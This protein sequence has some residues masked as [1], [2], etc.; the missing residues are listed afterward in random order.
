MEER[1]ITAGEIARLI[2]RRIVWILALSAAAALAAGLFTAF[3]YNRAREEYFLTFVVELPQETAFRYETLVY[4]D[5]LE[6]AK[7]S[8]G[9]FAA[10][11]TERMAANEDIRI[12]R[13]GGEGE[14]PSYTVTVKG[15]YFSDRAQA[16]GFLR[17]VVE[18]AVSRTPSVLRLGGRAAWLCR[19]FADRSVTGAQIRYR[20][21][22]V[23]VSE[24]GI[25][26]LLAAF[27]A[28]A[29]V[30][31]LSSAL[32]C[33]AQLSALRREHGTDAPPPRPGE[34]ALSGL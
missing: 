18:H 24:G 15:R 7:A 23:S 32:F 9:A 25:S 21:N 10:V 20:Q 27:F 30:F 11:D 1:D 28:F 12:T 5:N 29:A 33:A 31:L 19:V 22:T 3:V 16:T 17:A 34:G 4:A 2:R 14:L 6:A 26:P 13:T 8:D